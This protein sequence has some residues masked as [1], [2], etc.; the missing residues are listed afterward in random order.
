MDLRRLLTCLLAAALFQFVGAL[1]ISARPRPASFAGHSMSIAVQHLGNRISS[2]K[3]Q[4]G[5]EINKRLLEAGIE[6]LR[7][8]EAELDGIF[9]C[10]EAL[11]TLKKYALDPDPK[12]REAIA[13]RLKLYFSPATLQLLIQQ[14]EKYPSE[15]S[16]VTYTY[17]ADHPCYFFAKVKT[18]SLTQAL[19]ARIKARNEDE[20]ATEIRLLACLS[21]KDAPARKFLEEMSQAAFPVHLSEDDRR[22]QLNLVT[23]ALAEAGVKE[24]EAKVLADIEAAAA[25]G[26]PAAIQAVLE[27]LKGFSNCNILQAFARLI[28][29]KRAVS[30]EVADNGKI[31]KLEARVGDLAVSAFTGAFGNAITGESDVAWKRHTDAELE[32]VYQRIKQ[33]LAGR[34]FSSCR[35]FR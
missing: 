17:A 16:A 26:N 12:V 33:A 32:R 21:R 2:C 13:Y 19:V 20:G 10:R 1:G 22:D 18:S 31:G 11:P 15:A 8:G 23:Y 6:K 30:L 14:I 24:D 28:L 34:K 29:D 5:V 4:K 3:G 7:A 35:S 25:T 27:K 9:F